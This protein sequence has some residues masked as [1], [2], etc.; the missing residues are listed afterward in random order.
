MQTLSAEKEDNIKKTLL[1]KCTQK[2]S[3]YLRKI[4]KKHLSALTSKLS[5]NLIWFDIK[6]VKR[7]YHSLYVL[8]I[9]PVA[10]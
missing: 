7:H 3:S 2:M 9:R 10:L 8:F 5:S 1:F 6:L 4:K